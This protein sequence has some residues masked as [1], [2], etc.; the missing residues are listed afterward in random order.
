MR[1]RQLLLLLGGSPAFEGAAD[2]FVPAAGG[3]DARI[4]LLLQGGEG[5]RRHLADYT[6]PWRRRGVTRCQAIMP[7]VDGE[8]N[9]PTAKEIIS[10][11]TGIFIGGGHTPT[12][13]RLYALEPIRTL[14]RNRYQ[15]GIPIAG[16][17]AGALIAPDVCAMPPEKTG[18]GSVTILPGLGLVGD[19]II[20]VHLTESHALP[21]MLEAMVGTHTQTGWG[22]DGSACVIFE[23][24]RFSRVLGKSAYHVTMT[25]FQTGAHDV[26][27]YADR[28]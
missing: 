5:S 10:H 21:T 8:L 4:A 11:A 3:R 16:V 24:G 23:D 15:E 26:T 6:E 20:G 9:L 1:R 2:E 13:H 27:R 25:D 7:G 19:L 18:D 28:E 17:S 22:I 12:Y 14:I